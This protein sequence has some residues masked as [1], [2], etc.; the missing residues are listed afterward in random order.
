MAE[1]ETQTRNGQK[2]KLWIGMMKKILHN[3]ILEYAIIRCCV[4][5]T[6]RYIH[7]KRLV[8]IRTMFMFAW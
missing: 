5:C 2:T 8:G 3:I 7:T 4:H 1:H 6:F